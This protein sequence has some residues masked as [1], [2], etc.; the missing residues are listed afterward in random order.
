MDHPQ[1][2][3][4]FRL[5]SLC[6]VIYKV[7]TKVISN[8]LRRFMPQ[9]I[10]PNQCSFVQGRQSVDNIILTQ[11]IIHSMHTLKN[12]RGF[13]VVKIDLEKAYDRIWW[14]FIF[15]CLSELNIPT[16]LC[17]VIEACVSSP[18]MQ[19]TW[20]GHLIQGAVD[21]GE[22]R[23]FQ[24]NKHGTAISHLFFADDL[25]LFSE[26]NMEQAGIMK[27]TLDDFCAL[28][29][30]RVN[31]SKTR[32][33]FSPC[34]NHT[35]VTEISDFLGFT[36][37]IDL[38]KYLGRPIIH[39]RVT[40]STYNGILEKMHSQLSTWK[41]N[42]LSF[43]ARSTLVSSVAT[44]MPSYAMQTTRLPKGTCDRIDKKCRD[45]LWGSTTSAQKV[46]LLAW[47]N[48]CKSKSDGGLGLRQA[49]FQNKAFMM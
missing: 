25:I 6:N 47:D 14:D 49:R 9:V 29:G 5:I 37:T 26:A 1:T 20:N 7:I 3:R 42:T 22:W 27:A 4:D 28:L 19:L 40:K 48:V 16:Y 30:Q 38:G 17:K 33:F 8:R 12:K 44:A 46:Y 39:K 32:V 23:P 15:D 2:I 43:T 35:R 36:P 41:V 18:S 21:S 24:L 13:M 31:A 11:E 34:I 45:F 10:A